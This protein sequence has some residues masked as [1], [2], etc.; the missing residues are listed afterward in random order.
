M[1][2]GLLALL[3]LVPKPMNKCSS[4]SRHSLW[5]PLHL[6]TEKVVSFV[7]RVVALDIFAW[8]S[9]ISTVKIINGNA[10]GALIIL[11]LI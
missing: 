7:I 6:V 1:S 4:K 2:E 9:N 5:S 3:S 11:I 10:E 8:K